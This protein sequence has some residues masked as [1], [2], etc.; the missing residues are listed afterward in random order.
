MPQLS[1]LKSFAHSMLP[2]FH[3]LMWKTH[4][5]VRVK[6]NKIL[7]CA[8]VT[9]CSGWSELPWHDR[10]SDKSATTISLGCQTTVQDKMCAVLSNR[11]QEGSQ[12]FLS[13][14][15]T[16]MLRRLALGLW[17]Q[18]VRKSW[19]FI[20]IQTLKFLAGFVLPASIKTAQCVGNHFLNG[21]NR[22]LEPDLRW[23]L[24]LFIPV[25]VCVHGSH[26]KRIECIWIFQAMTNTIRSSLCFFFLNKG[27]FYP[28]AWSVCLCW[29]GLFPPQPQLIPQNRAP[30]LF[31]PAL[32]SPKCPPSVAQ[33]QQH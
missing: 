22:R 24:T 14:T 29:R 12:V 33:Q 20:F 11:G 4:C 15:G 7:L 2:Y 27:P 9:L 17:K 32:W 3:Y 30:P 19:V 21:I 23:P 8:Y 18:D 25:C 28:H 6:G 1:Y 31:Q 10:R 5:V 26:N 16:K 13:P